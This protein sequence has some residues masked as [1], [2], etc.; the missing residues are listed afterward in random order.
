SNLLLRLEDY[1]RA[2][3]REH[4]RSRTFEEWKQNF[5]TTLRRDHIR[6]SE[7]PR[8]DCAHRCKVSYRAH[9]SWEGC[10]RTLRCPWCG[11]EKSHRQGCGSRRPDRYLART[12]GWDRNCTPPRAP[13]RRA[14]STWFPG[15]TRESRDA[16]R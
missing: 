15:C 11:R 14:A 2:R 4:N 5:A 9:L 7:R 10:D 16:F 13:L 12:Y 8:F 6:R 1:L 3:L